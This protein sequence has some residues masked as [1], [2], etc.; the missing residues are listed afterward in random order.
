MNN[1]EPILEPGQNSHSEWYQVLLYKSGFIF[2]N[3]F[4][5][6]AIIWSL[7]GFVVGENVMWEFTTEGTVQEKLLPYN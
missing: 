2:A 5:A 1:G 7:T 6:D 3:H 4:T